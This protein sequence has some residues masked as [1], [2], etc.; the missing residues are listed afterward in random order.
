MSKRF[1]LLKPFVIEGFC[2]YSCFRTKLAINCLV[3]R[4]NNIKKNEYDYTFY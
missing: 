2:S 1:K 4:I 3:M